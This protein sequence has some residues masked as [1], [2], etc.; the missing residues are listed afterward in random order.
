MKRDRKTQGRAELG[1]W[2]QQRQ[3]EIDLRKNTNV[4]SQA[5][6]HENLK[7]QRNGPNPWERVISNCEMNG[8][9][10]VGGGDVTRMR[11]AMIARKADLTKG[12]AGKGGASKSLI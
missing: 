10:Y 4:E 1:K 8:S 3:K 11:Q 2:S 5:M 7:A 9:Q 12:A 6:Y